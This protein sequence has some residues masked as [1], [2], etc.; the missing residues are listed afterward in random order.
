MAV[1]ILQALLN[2][3]FFIPIAFFVDISAVYLITKLVFHQDMFAMMKQSKNKRGLFV[4]FEDFGDKGFSGGRIDLSIDKL[5]EGGQLALLNAENIALKQELSKIREKVAKK[6]N[7][8]K[9]RD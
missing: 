4:S 6:E 7:V 1:S 9:T 5:T 2:D 3:A 8:Q